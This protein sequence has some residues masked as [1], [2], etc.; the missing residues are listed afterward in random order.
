[1]MLLVDSSDPIGLN[2]E[3]LVAWFRL[4]VKAPTSIASSGMVPDGG[5]TIKLVA[6]GHLNPNSSQDT[7]AATIF[8]ILQIKDSSPNLQF[9]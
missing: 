6:P 5:V 2:Y 3:C 8:F 9:R 7:I 4:T 1:M